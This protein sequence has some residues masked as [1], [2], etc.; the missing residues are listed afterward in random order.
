MKVEFQANQ[1]RVVVYSP[2]WSNPVMT[3]Y[4]R[5]NGRGLGIGTCSVLP[6]DIDEAEEMARAY[7]EAIELA[8][9]KIEKK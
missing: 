1:N 6:T 3:I 9:E 8:K 4:D 5:G 7:V 2:K